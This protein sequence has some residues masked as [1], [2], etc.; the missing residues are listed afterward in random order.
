MSKQSFRELG[1]SRTCRRRARSRKSNRAL[2]DPGARPSRCARRARRPRP[3]RRPDRARRSPSRCRSSSA[4]CRATPVRRRSCSSRHG[5]SRPRSTAELERLA[6]AQGPLRRRHLRRHAPAGAGERAPRAPRSSSPR[7]GGSRTSPS[8][9][10]STSRRVRTFVLD[11]ADRM[12]DMGFKPQVDRIVRRL[13]RNRQTMFFSATLDG[14]AGELARAYTNS[15]SRFEA[16]PAAP[17]I[18]ARSST[19]SWR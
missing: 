11:E 2:P 4:R 10:S 17:T 5:S 13:P 19:A 6:Q 9:V 14:E 8:A 7:P 15:P 3:R 16:E 18:R 1:V 12:L